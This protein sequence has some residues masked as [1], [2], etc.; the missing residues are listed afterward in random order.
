V[1]AKITVRHSN[2]YV[3][4]VTDASGRVVGTYTHPD[5]AR[6]ACD[7]ENNGYNP[8]AVNEAIEASNRAGRRIGKREAVLIHRLMKGRTSC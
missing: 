5:A 8:Q 1:P 7:R 2:A 4:D 3:A 6:F